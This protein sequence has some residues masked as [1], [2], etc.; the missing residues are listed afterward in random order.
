MT[1]GFLNIFSFSALVAI[2][3]FVGSE[4]S[5]HHLATM[6]CIINPLIPACV[7]VYFKPSLAKSLIQVWYG[8]MQDCCVYLYVSIYITCIYIYTRLAY[9]RIVI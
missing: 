7:Y 2:K 4:F 3:F 1:F 5:F 6:A 8:H 9:I